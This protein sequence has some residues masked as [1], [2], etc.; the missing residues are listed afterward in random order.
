MQQIKA[1]IVDDEL[2]SIRVLTKLLGHVLPGGLNN[3]IRSICSIG[4][5]TNNKK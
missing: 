1:F 4:A 3:G 2:R 5:R